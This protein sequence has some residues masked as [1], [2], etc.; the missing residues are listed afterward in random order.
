MSP[1]LYLIVMVG[2]IVGLVLVIV[3]S[4]IFKKC[5]SCSARNV[6]DADQ[7]RTCGHGFPK[8]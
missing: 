5:S 7:C 4:L 2:I 6:I 1:G 3:P 8:A